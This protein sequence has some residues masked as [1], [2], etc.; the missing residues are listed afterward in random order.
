MS[1]VREAVVVLTAAVLGVVGIV[2]TSGC[3]CGGRLAPTGDRP[4]EVQTTCDASC[5]A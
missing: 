3:G 5:C 1:R 2:H 4:W